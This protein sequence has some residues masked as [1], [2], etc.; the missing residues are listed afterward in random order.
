MFWPGRARSGSDENAEYLEFR[1]GLKIGGSFDR[2]YVRALSW[3]LD[4]VD[5]FFG[6]AGRENPTWTAA[7]YDR[8]LWLA[9]VYPVAT[10]LAVWVASGQVGVAELRSGWNGEA[11]SCAALSEQLRS[12]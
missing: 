4:R 10:M 8:C 5:I 2:A 7:S 6:D 12:C 11:C 3:A 9:L 1:E